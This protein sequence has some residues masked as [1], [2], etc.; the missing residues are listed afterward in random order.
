MC[1]FHLWLN[2]SVYTCNPAHIVC[3]PWLKEMGY[4]FDV[5]CMLVSLCWVVYFSTCLL[6]LVD[7]W[8]E[9]YEQ[10]QVVA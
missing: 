3:Y 4:C 1:Y 6:N 7:L 5:V 9:C 8:Q 10:L 2:D